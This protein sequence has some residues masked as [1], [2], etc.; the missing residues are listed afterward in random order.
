M[1]T[2]SGYKHGI[3]QIPLQHVERV[4]FRVRIAEPNEA[5]R[6]RGGKTLFSGSHCPLFKDSNTLNRKK[7]AAATLETNETRTTVS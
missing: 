6:I 2:L 3:L 1:P 7:D 4:G 5:A